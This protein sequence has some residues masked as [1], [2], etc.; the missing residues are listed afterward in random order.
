[1]VIIGIEEVTDILAGIAR[2]IGDTLEKAKPKKVTVEVGVEFGLEVG[3]L[4]ALI[5]RGTGKVNLKIS[6][7]WE[8]S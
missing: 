6:L 7:E 1:M 8:R 5:A 4:V 2:S 3:K